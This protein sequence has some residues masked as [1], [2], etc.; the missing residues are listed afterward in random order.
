MTNDEDDKLEVSHEA[1]QSRTA[2]AQYLRAIAD[3]LESGTLRL[4]S[5]QTSLELHP[6]RLIGFELDGRRE[7]GRARLRVRLAWREDTQGEA[8]ALR[9]ASK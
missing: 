1:L 7:R 3:G 6:Q 5:E 4:S 8:E 2:V 9:I